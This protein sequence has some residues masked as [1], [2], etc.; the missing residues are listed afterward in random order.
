MFG[1]SEAELLVFAAARWMNE[2]VLDEGEAGARLG[3]TLVMRD[4]DLVRDA[5]RGSGLR[6]SLTGT[7]TALGAMSTPPVSSRSVLPPECV[8]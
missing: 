2:G 5:A 6:R 1:R 7:G 8:S 3:E 4:R